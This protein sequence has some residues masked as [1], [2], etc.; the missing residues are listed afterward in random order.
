MALPP[1]LLL[2]PFFK[3]TVK[4]TAAKKFVACTT[5]PIFPYPGARHPSCDDHAH[6][7][8]TCC[9]QH[10]FESKGVDFAAR[11]ALPNI[12]G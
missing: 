1:E 11:H 6:Q 10:P 12:S 2:G 9:L 4:D 3:S 5:A 7:Q 8:Q